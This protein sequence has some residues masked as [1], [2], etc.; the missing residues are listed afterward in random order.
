MVI[1]STRSHLDSAFFNALPGAVYPPLAGTALYPPLAGPATNRWHSIGMR[2]EP[3]S[4]TKAASADR[5]R[6]MMRSRTAG[7]RRSPS[8]VPGGAP[9]SRCLARPGR[10]RP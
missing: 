4:A 8:G 1:L 6:A 2:A 5:V 9:A 10:F 3:S 7:S